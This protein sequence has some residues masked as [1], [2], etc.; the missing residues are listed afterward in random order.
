MLRLPVS[1]GGPRRR[2]WEAAIEVAVVHHAEPYNSRV[3]SMVPCD[4]TAG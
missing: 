3:E 1:T 2:R 4:V